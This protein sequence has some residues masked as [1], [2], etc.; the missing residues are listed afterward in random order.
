MTFSMSTKTQPWV[1]VFLTC[2]LLFAAQS[3]M[4]AGGLGSAESGLKDF[5]T[6]FHGIA[7]ILAMFGL[8][9]CAVM[10]FM[11]MKHWGD[12]FPIMGWIAVAGATPS[13]VKMIWDWGKSS[14]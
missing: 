4:A 1:K 6:S 13:I 8:L 5:F 9:G 10:G 14:L 12:L 3:A 2:S 11:G 7:L